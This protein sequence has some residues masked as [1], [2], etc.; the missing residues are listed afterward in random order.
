M[1][2]Q[3]QEWRKPEPSG[4]ADQGRRGQ[5]LYKARKPWSKGG[6]GT[7]KRGTGF[8]RFLGRR[9]R[10]GQGQHAL[11]C[12]DVRG[13]GSSSAGRGSKLRALISTA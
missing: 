11:N 13:Q 6:G 4:G 8:E 12:G 2:L 7:R 1:V 3:G 5:S 9:R 10:R